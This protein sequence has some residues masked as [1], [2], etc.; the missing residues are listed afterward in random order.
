MKT[1]IRDNGLS[2]LH[3]VFKDVLI[4]LKGATSS[5]SWQFLAIEET[6]RN[7]RAAIKIIN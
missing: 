1:I 2:T 7:E 6:N 3:S 4:A 5:S